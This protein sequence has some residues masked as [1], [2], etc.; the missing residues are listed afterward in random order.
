MRFKERKLPANAAL[1]LKRC[2]VSTVSPYAP[3][4]V[5]VYVLMKRNKKFICVKG[6][7]DFFEPA[8]LERLKPLENLFVPSFIESAQ[9][10]QKAAR[11]VKA[12]LQWTPRASTASAG[13]FPMVPLSPSSFELSD[14]ILRILGPLW[15]QGIQIEPYFMSIFASELCGLLDQKLLIEAKSKDVESYELA[16]IKSGCA[17]FLAFH[18]GYRQLDFLNELRASFFKE[19]VF[20]GASFANDEILELSHLINEWIFEPECTGISQMHF[21]DRP[22]KV[23]QKLLSRIQ[24]IEKELLPPH[25]TWSAS[26]FGPKGLVDLIDE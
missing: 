1:R 20:E 9:P 19:S 3:M 13:H 21:Q 18:L 7:L 8:E 26:I 12:L 22:E 24:R 23:A 17:V 2:P 4:I 10:F 11:A 25:D 6:P 15:G 16:L 5:P 14:S